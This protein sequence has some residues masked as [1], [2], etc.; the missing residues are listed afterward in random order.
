MDNNI[1]DIVVFVRVV[2]KQSFTAAARDLILSPSAVSRHISH[3]EESLG[4]QLIKRSTR[5]LVLTDIGV[6]F[7]E[8]CARIIRDLDRARGMA[9]A[10]NVEI[11]GTLRVHATLGLG[12][13]LVAPAV[14]E[15]L[16]HYPDINIDLAIGP[17][18]VN[19]FE[20]EGYD[21]IIRSA[22]LNDNSL[23]TRE[24]SP[25]QYS[26]CAT[27][28]FLEKFGTPASPQ[29]LKNF[30]CLVHSGQTRADEWRFEENGE[31]FTVI[32]RG[33]LRTN[34]GIALYEAV[35]GGLGIA[36]LPGYA[37][38]GDLRAGQLVPLF[39]NLV[40]WGRSI[41]AFYPRTA[42]QPLRVRVFLDF[43]ADFMRNKSIGN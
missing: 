34:N 9:S 13:R 11:K 43:V 22:R 31:T 6:D 14:R 33:N 15:F 41:K 10:H 24:L 26:V 20:D 18:T 19:V 4:V 40:G 36:R 42:H 5:R 39:Q 32:V 28:G 35:K 8:Q 16:S 25:V 23:T 12:Q 17:H 29:D 7:Y 30:N 27:P 3:L 38:A 2:E 21:I 37:V 1:S